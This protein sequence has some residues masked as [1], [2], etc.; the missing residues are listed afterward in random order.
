MASEKLNQKKENFAKWY[1]EVVKKAKLCDYSKI[2]GIY[3][4]MPY[5]YEIWEKISTAFDSLIKKDGVKNA[6]FP[7]F[8]TESELKKEAEHFKGFIPEVAWLQEKSGEERIAIRPT[9]EAIMYPFFSKWIESYRDLPIRI[10]QWCNVVRWEIKMTHP[11]IRSREFLWQEGH[12]AHASAEEAKEEALRALKRY[13][14]FVEEYLALEVIDGRKPESEKFP[15]AEIT[16]TFEI[17]MPDG[18]AL[19]LGTS[20]FLSQNF[21]KAFGIKFKKKDGSYDFVYQTSWGITTRLIGAIVAIHG[22]DK[23][24]VLP[25]R[26]APIQAI[27]IPT[28]IEKEVVD[29]CKDLEKRLKEKGIRV[30]VDIDD[31]HSFGW[32]LNHYDLI[33]V[34]LK[35]EVG[36]KEVSEKEITVVKRN[37]LKK[38]KIKI[39]EL[40]K[41][42]EIL[43]EIQ[44]EMFEK[45]KEYLKE[46]IAE[47]RSKE[48]I[49][50]NLAKAKIC[51]ISWCESE[52]C[53]KELSKEFSLRVITN[54]K[55]FEEKCVCGRKAKSTLYLASSAY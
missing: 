28:K 27:I 2:H 32:K 13:K 41:V 35:I 5:G 4:I 24:L 11:F 3:A 54:E 10:N 44:R 25:P 30:E 26:I 37:D 52:E 46:R 53:E 29:F 15:G 17:L 48:E 51:K 6:Y 8:V 18:K 42:N 38:L 22:D 7:L 20:H 19:Q 43:E 14:E 50:E 39:D 16:Y 40:F 31:K 34:P 1:E 49:K 36:K 45:A 55:P 9:S 23:G 12:T 47:A 21:S 33:G